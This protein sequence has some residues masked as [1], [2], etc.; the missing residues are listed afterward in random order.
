MLDRTKSPDFQLIKSHQLPKINTKKLKNGISFHQLIT[1]NQPVLGF[2]IAFE[3]GRCQENKTGEAS[4]MAKM[5]LEGTQTNTGKQIA[6]KISFYGAS[7]QVDSGNDFTIVSFYTLEKH[8]EHLLPLLKEILQEPTFPQSEIDNL[9]NRSVQNLKIQEERTAYRATVK[10]KEVLF[11]ENHPYSASSSE[12]SIRAIQRQ[13]LIDFYETHIK[14]NPFEAYLV[15][16][17]DADSEKLITNFIESFAVDSDKKEKQLLENP[18]NSI[19]KIY[20]EIEGSVQTSIRIGRLLFNQK[21][22]DYAA[23]KVMNMILGGYFG[24]RLM[25]NIREDKGYTYGISSRNAAMKNGSYFVIGTDVKKEIY[26]DAVNEIYKEIER[27]KNEPVSEEELENVK[28]YMSGNFLGSLS[29]AFAVMDKMQD[30]H[31]YNL[32]EN[33]YNNYITNLRKV[34]VE[35]VQKMAQKYLVDLTEVCIG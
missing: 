22:P 4:F 13:D 17:I 30:I 2:Q 35:N 7:I 34:T 15:G 29:T 26:Q 11:K 27:L 16:D 12:Q 32:D 25:Q 19:T 9:K 14:S 1:K 23:F 24:S 20:E 10:I 3:A 21:H 28:N 31:L 33:Y 5:L 6:D 8:L 18:T